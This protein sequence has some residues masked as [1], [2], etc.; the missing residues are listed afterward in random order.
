[1]IGDCKKPLT[2]L[3]FSVN[4]P[5]AECD[6]YVT[7]VYIGGRRRPGGTPMGGYQ[8]DIT[9]EE[10]GGSSRSRNRG[11]GNGNQH[12][13]RGRQARCIESGR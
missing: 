10:V 6:T 8:H 2:L 1:M 9:K 12:P 3:R 11:V 4:H 13:G 5:C 7:F